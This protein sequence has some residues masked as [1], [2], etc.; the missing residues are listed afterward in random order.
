MIL[1][2]LGMEGLRVPLLGME[3]VEKARRKVEV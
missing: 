3:A 1:L 2:L